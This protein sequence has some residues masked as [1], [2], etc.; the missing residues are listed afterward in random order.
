MIKKFFVAVVLKLR[1]KVV[2]IVLENDRVT[3]N[4]FDI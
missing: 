4:V 1:K 3:E 2:M